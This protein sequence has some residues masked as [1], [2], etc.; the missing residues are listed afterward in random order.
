MEGKTSEKLTEFRKLL[1][2]YEIDAYYLPRTDAHESE[3]LPAWEE[4]LKFISGFSG[5]N[6]KAFVSKSKAFCW[7]DGRYF[8]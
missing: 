5:S 7:T 4:R 2:K 6:G 1:S 8:I 3:Y